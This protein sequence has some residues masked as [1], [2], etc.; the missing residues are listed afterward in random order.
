MVVQTLRAG[1]LRRKA[2]VPV[3]DIRCLRMQIPGV[4]LDAAWRGGVE[5]GVPFVWL[6]SWPEHRPAKKESGRRNRRHKS[7]A[8]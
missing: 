6:A 1:I 4:L 3:A 7:G 5:D 2:G 8:N